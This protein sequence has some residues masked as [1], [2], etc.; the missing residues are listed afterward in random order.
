MAG[1]NSRFDLQGRVV[2]I[3]GGGKGIGKVYA[4]EFA[5]AG[6]R[7]VAAE[8][9]ASAAQAVAAAIAE[10]GGEA[11]ALTTDIADAASAEAMAART[12]KRFGTIDVLI[13]NS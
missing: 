11:L 4:T 5:R 7:V 9:D 3:T 13:N 6:A 1:S 8:I 10:E 2:V 12:V